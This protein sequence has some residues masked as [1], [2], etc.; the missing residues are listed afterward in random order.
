[1]KYNEA[2]LYKQRL[3]KS[4]MPNPRQ[5]P[6]H[7]NHAAL[8]NP[9]PILVSKPVPIPVT[10]IPKAAVPR[11]RGSVEGLNQEIE[12]LVLKSQGFFIQGTDEEEKVQPAANAAQNQ[13]TTPDGHR[14]P[15]A[16]LLR[17][18]SGT[19]SVNTQTPSVVNENDSGNS[20]GGGSRSQSISPSFPIIPGQMDSSRPSSQNDSTE[21]TSD[22]SKVDKVDL[23]PG[24]PDP[25][26]KY[27][28]SPRPN[29]SYQFVREPP[30]GCE[31]VPLLDETRKAPPMPPMVKEPLLDPCKKFTLKVS[32]SSAFCPL[33]FPTAPEFA[34]ISPVMSQN[35]LGTGIQSQ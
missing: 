31:K 29:K 27:A 4:K 28:A 32:D 13:D 26:S 18:A 9:P 20:S 11:V 2:E 6:I 23:D 8:T 14:A 33:K 15:I 22:G 16:E 5:S 10:H 12:R 30:D 25:Q 34:V 19:R 17:A 1:M 35:P 7:G 21:N 3:Q 24:S